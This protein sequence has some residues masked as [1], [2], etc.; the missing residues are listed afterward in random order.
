MARPLKYGFKTKPI[1]YAIPIDKFKEIDA[2]FK[3][4]LKSYEVKPKSKAKKLADR[5]KL[6]LEETELFCKEIKI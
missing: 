1:P 3:E 4:I 2:K 5:F 6:N